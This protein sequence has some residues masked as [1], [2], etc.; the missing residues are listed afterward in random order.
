MPNAFVFDSVVKN[1]SSGARISQGPR[2]VHTS[3]RGLS[4]H[5]SSRGRFIRCRSRLWGACKAGLLAD[6]GYALVVELALQVYVGRVGLPLHPECICLRCHGRPGQVSDAAS[7]LQRVVRLFAG[8]VHVIEGLVINKLLQCRRIE[9]HQMLAS[10]SF[11][12]VS[13]PKT[14]SQGTTRTAFVL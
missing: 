7:R 14:F 1:H 9:I 4:R 12:P 3:I 13:F 6:S 8:I 2:P 11:A 10:W 5:L